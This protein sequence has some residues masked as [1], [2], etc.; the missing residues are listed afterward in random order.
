[1][2][3]HTESPES[4]TNYD[5]VTQRWKKTCFLS[6]RWSLCKRSHANV[7]YIKHKAAVCFIYCLLFVCSTTKR[8]NNIY[9][10]QSKAFVNEKNAGLSHQGLHKT[11]KLYSKSP[12]HNL[13]F[14]LE[15]KIRG[16][17]K[18]VTF[19]VYLKEWSQGAKKGWPLN[20]PWLL[21]QRGPVE[22]QPRISD[23]PWT[24]NDP[25]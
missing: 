14:L 11:M 15:Q 20:P 13:K 5:T 17:G 8:T 6:W 25:T 16:R 19:W 7:G 10:E 2:P 23:W 18:M 12:F 22:I 21:Q 4:L 24:C 3:Q 1:M 9:L